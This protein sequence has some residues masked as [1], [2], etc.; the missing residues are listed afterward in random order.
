MDCSGSVSYV[1][2]HAGY[3]V[4]T[5]VSGGIGGWGFPSGPGGATIFYNAGHTFMRIGNRYW[6]TSGFGHPGFGGAGWFTV[7]PGAGYLA[8][9]KSV[10]LPGIGD[11]GDFSTALGGDI[12]QLLVRGPDS[13]IKQFIQKIFD[14]VTEVANDKISSEASKFDAG[15]GQ[16]IDV[17]GV[18]AGAGNIFRFFKEQ[19]FTDEQAAAWVGNFTQESGLNPAIVQPGGEGHGLAQ[20]GHGRFDALVAFAGQ[21]G[22]PWT[23]LGTQL[24]FVMHELHGSEGAAY[25]RIKG[26]KTLEAAVDAVGIGYERFGIQGDRYGPARSAL[27]RFGGQF[28]EGGIVPGGDGT[29][30]GAIVHAGE[31]ILNKVQ[32]ARMAALTGLHPSSLASM[33]GFHG[34]KG[35]YQ[36]GTS[37]V[38]SASQDKPNEDAKKIADRTAK[39]IAKI[40]DK[41]LRVLVG[42]LAKIMVH[43]DKIAVKIGTVESWSREIDKEVDGMHKVAQRALRRPGKKGKDRETAI[44]GFADAMDKLLN[45]ETGAFARLR[46]RIEERTARVQRSQIFQ[47]FH[48]AQIRGAARGIVRVVQDREEEEQARIA[49]RDTRRER[50]ALLTERRETRTALRDV[51][52]QLA[53]KGLS[54]NARQRLVG[55]QKRLREM[56]ADADQRVADNLQSIYEAQQAY[57]QAQLDAQQK[58]VDA[59]NNRYERA[60]GGVDRAKRIADALGQDTAGLAQAQRDLLTGQANELQGRIASLRAVGSEDAIKA[61]DALSD[62][63]ADIRVQIFESIQQSIADAA[64]RI[65]QQAQRSLG[66]LDLVGRMAD[67]MGKIGLGGVGTVLGQSLSRSQIGQARVD[68][69]QG[70]RAGIAGVLAQAQGQGNIKLIQ[71]LTDQ[72]AELD[73]TIKETQQANFTARIEDLNTRTNNNLNL[74]SLD[75]QI[76]DLKGTISGQID[77]AAVVANLTKVGNELSAQRL[78]LE[79][80]LAEAIANQDDQ[81]IYD[82]TVQLK[83]NEI[84]SLNNTSALNDANGLMKNPQTFSSS[85]WQWF[86]EAIF[87]GM[88]QVLPQYDSSAINTGAVIVPSSAT[89]NNGGDVNVT[90]NEAGGPIDITAV[91]SAIV[92]A[93]KTAQ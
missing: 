59:I 53:R 51:N 10:H 70:Q 50:P 52:R 39:E 79:G 55:E 38:Q 14:K 47:R 5:T 40:S 63:V 68:V 13:P 1:T 30:V 25:S 23:D 45:E 27:Q 87:S 74:L 43:F 56:Y 54:D 72:L 93:S 66:R 31:W 81:A 48:T 16:D 32:Q 58:F 20:W 41:A 73:V 21:H 88:G 84:A 6:G 12:K 77:Q 36:G 78:G 67:A 83:E 11:V 2:Q 91:T 44:L 17:K 49:L 4:P 22:K 69:L 18:A 62:Q 8:G 35:H 82:L 65:N 29:P 15:S 28:A 92:F 89:T 57:I 85:A 42:S 71:D 90:V 7:K 46:T 61:A 76:I 24:A 80:L 33:L 86:N 37:D 64:D 19:G 60:L 26:A 34:S 75:K 3:K 9:F